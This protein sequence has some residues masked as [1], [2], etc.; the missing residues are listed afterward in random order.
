MTYIIY[1][2]TAPDG[3]I[4]IGMTKQGLEG[5]AK[6]GYGYR[7]TPQF[8]AAIQSFGWDNFSHEI[9]TEGLTR[10]EAKLAER[11][12][13]ALFESNKPGIGF[14]VDAGGSSNIRP[15]SA[16]SRMKMA[17]SHKG[18]PL[19]EE[20]KANISAA[21]KGKK[22][23]PQCQAASVKA[24]SRAVICEETDTIYS[25]ISEAARAIGAKNSCL[26]QC[27]SGRNKTAAGYHWRYAN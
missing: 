22:V 3:R 13:I 24:R 1:K 9:L 16:E 10:E 20:H 23:T 19:S 26:S 18:V 21:L 6:G 25:S 27:L 8:F 2:H 7:S 17:A 4:Y 11:H 12:F 14:N 15:I 5:R